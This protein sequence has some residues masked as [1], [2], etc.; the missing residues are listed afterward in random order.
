MDT[1]VRIVERMIRIWVADAVRAHPLH[2][3]TVTTPVLWPR[4]HVMIRR[5]VDTADLAVTDARLVSHQLLATDQDHYLHVVKHQEITV[6]SEYLLPD[7]TLPGR[8]PSQSP[9]APYRAQLRFVDR[10]PRSN[11]LSMKRM[12]FAWFEYGLPCEEPP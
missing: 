11:T 8:V 3:L 2:Q 1:L 12:L 4:N 6:P 7:H 9:R 10:D 5:V